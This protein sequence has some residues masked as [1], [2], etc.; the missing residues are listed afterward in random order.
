MLSET[1]GTGR[2][3]MDGL[4]IPMPAPLD[5]R[6]FDREFATRTSEADWRRITDLRDHPRMLDGVLR[7]DE[8]IPDYF[9]DNI[10]LNRV[11]IEL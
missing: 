8:L 4:G 6:A 9:A 1:G 5:L 11:V 7:Y 10:I 2:I 3:M